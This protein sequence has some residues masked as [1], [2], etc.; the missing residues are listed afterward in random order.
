M[1]TSLSFQYMKISMHSVLILLALKPKML[2]LEK[3]L[4]QTKIAAVKSMN[5]NSLKFSIMNA[6]EL[7][8]ASLILK[9]K[10]S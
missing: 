1:V 5:K 6:L 7:N 9:I 4:F 2:A 10:I 3:T 8:H